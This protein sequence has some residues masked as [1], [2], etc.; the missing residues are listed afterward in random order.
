MTRPPRDPFLT[1]GSAFTGALEE[2]QAIAR[3]LAEA[4]DLELTLG[5]L[6][7]D[8]ARLALLDLLVSAR[9]ALLRPWQW[10]RLG[11][12]SPGDAAGNHRPETGALL[13][14]ALAADAASVPGRLAIA[15]RDLTDPV[16]VL[17]DLM[18]LLG[19]RR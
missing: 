5:A 11:T 18:A 12:G 16:E 13:G 14:I 6:D 17:V 4:P 8:D 19:V 3:A 1:D 7:G 10:E 9:F 2:G 15:T